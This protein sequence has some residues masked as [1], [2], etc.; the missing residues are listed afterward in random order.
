VYERIY[1]STIKRVSASDIKSG[2][3][4]LPSKTIREFSTL[5]RTCL[6]EDMEINVLLV[7]VN[8]FVNIN[9]NKV[10]RKK[11]RVYDVRRN[12][13]RSPEYRMYVGENLPVRVGDRILIVERIGTKKELAIFYPEDKGLMSRIVFELDGYDIEYGFNCK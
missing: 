2:E 13:N 3:I 5:R 8:E 4:L 1:T 9:Y 10:E 7:P 6:V 11:A 12:S